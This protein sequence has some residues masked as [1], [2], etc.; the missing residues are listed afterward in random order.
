[1]QGALHPSLLL[2]LLVLQPGGSGRAE[3]G[4]MELSGILGGSVTFPLEIP[5]AEQ[6]ENA[7]WTVN[8]KSLVTVAAGK[9]PSVLLIDKKDYLRRLRI[10]D[11]SYSLQLA[12]LQTKDTG[13]YRADVNTDKGSVTKLFTLRVYKQVP[14]P[15]V[16]CDSVTCGTETCNYSL[17]CT[18]GDG[19]DNVTYSWTHRAGG[20]VVPSGS[21][22]HISLRPQDAPLNVTCTAQNPASHSSTTAS[23]TG[24]CAGSGRAEAGAMDLS[25]LVGDSVTFPLRIPAQQLITVSWTVNTTSSIVIVI[26][27]NPP[28]VIVSDPSYE[29]RLSVP[30]ESN[31][32]QINSL[33]MQDTGTYGAEISTVTGTIHRPFLLRVYKQV[34]E[35]TVLC[36]SVTCGTETCN[37]TLRCTIGD[38]GDNVTYSWTHSA[39]GAVVPSGSVLHISQRPLAVTCTAQNPVSHSSTT[40]SATGLCAAPAS[41][42][43]YCRLKGIILLPVL[44]AL[45]AGIIAVHVLPGRERRRD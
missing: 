38:G 29:G 1:M 25:R 34:P 6:F 37:Y 26:A 41:S 32:L 17:R 43:S 19:G 35:P 10:L 30:A 20:A 13:Q 18:I 42:L 39:G 24:L 27:G 36:D 16:L 3:A 14:E 11:E 22:L 9:P 28:N 15:T 44:G 21:V 40:A 5:A 45:S 12:H 23:A 4:V 33:R 2:L 7:G 8:S 31:S